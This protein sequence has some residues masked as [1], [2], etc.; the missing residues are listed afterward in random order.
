MKY[1]VRDAM[2][3]GI[4]EVYLNTDEEGDIGMYINEVEI[5]CLMQDG[6]VMMLP[7]ETGQIQ[8]LGVQI[9]EGTNEILVK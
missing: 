6:C 8:R 2:P 1:R 9:E 5:L 4:G 7:L 3:T